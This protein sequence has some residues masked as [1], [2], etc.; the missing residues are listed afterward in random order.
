M[1]DNQTTMTGSNKISPNKKTRRITMIVIFILALSPLIYLFFSDMFGDMKKED[2]MKNG[3]P[4]MAE[5]ISF[6]RTGTRMNGIYCLRF[7]VRVSPTVGTKSFVDEYEEYIDPID[8]YKLQPGVHIPAYV[9]KED[10]SEFVLM[11]E[12]AGIKIAF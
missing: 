6:D 1:E 12:D 10:P 9:D 4:A 8:Y 3:E 2:L 5:I 11:W 7:V